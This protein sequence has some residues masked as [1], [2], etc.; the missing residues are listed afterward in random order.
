MTAGSRL[1]RLLRSLKEPCSTFVHLI[2]FWI[3]VIDGTIRRRKTVIDLPHQFRPAVTTYP[4]AGRMNDQQW[5]DEIQWQ[6]KQQ[7]QE[8]IEGEEVYTVTMADFLTMPLV[9]F[10]E[11]ATVDPAVKALLN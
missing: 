3:N 5:L 2:V 10:L 7:P 1:K 8:S 9:N 11:L 6:D 4:Y